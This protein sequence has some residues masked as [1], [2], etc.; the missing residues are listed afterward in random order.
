MPQAQNQPT[1]VHRPMHFWVEENVNVD[2]QEGGSND[3]LPD[4]SKIV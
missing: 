1:F 3:A 2:A 4:T